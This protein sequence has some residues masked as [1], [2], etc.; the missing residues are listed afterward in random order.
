MSG[1][2]P[3]HGR[4]GQ[5]NTTWNPLQLAHMSSERSMARSPLTWHTPPSH[6]DKVYNLMTGSLMNNLENN[7][8]L[9][10][11]NRVSSSV[12]AP[13]GSV[14]LSL[15][16]ASRSTP[17]PKGGHPSQSLSSTVLP[18]SIPATGGHTVEL[19]AG[20]H[21]T[22]NPARSTAAGN[23]IQSTIA[24]T[25]STT[26]NS[27]SSA[28]A[29]AAVA[30]A[31]AIKERI[32][33]GSFPSPASFN[34]TNN[35][36]NGFGMSTGG[37][38]A[39]RTGNEL[40]TLMTGGL[41]IKDAKQINSEM[42][43]KNGRDCFSHLPAADSADLVKEFIMQTIQNSN[44][45]SV[46]PK[47]NS[48]QRS[49]LHSDYS[50]PNRSRSPPLN[51]GLLGQESFAALMNCSN[52]R[53][54]ADTKAAT[55][56]E[57]S[58]E[59]NNG[60]TAATT[61]SASCAGNIN[62]AASPTNHSITSNE[63]SVDSASGACSKSR[64]RRKPERTNK[65]NAMASVVVAGCGVLEG[66]DGQSFFNNLPDPSSTKLVGAAAKAPTSEANMLVEPLRSSIA[67]RTDITA[68][69]IEGINALS[70][71]LP[72]EPQTSNSCSTSNHS[73]TASMA[74]LA[75]RLNSVQGGV[76]LDGSLHQPHPNHH[77][78]LS[79]QTAVSANLIQSNSNLNNST[80]SSIKTAVSPS[81]SAVAPTSLIGGHNTSIT[82]NTSAPSPS[83]TTNASSLLSDGGLLSV[84][85]A[86]VAA[87]IDSVSKDMKST[88]G[89]DTASEECETL[90]K[91]AAMV[92]SV[93][94]GVTASPEA[95]IGLS[96]PF[97]STN[98]GTITTMAERKCNSNGPVNSHKS[99]S[100]AE[101]KV[102]C[103][104]NGRVNAS[105]SSYEE[106]ENKLEEMFAGIVEEKI[107]D[108]PLKQ[109]IV[110]S[111]SLHS[112]NGSNAGHNQAN[113][114][115]PTDETDGALLK[116]L[117]C[118]N[119]QTVVSGDENNRE[120]KT[121][122]SIANSGTP[123]GGNGAPPAAGSGK[124]PLTPAQK[125]ANGT[126][127]ALGEHPFPTT[128]T[129]VTAAK[130]KRGPKKKAKTSGS[131]F[132]E[133]ADKSGFMGLKALNTK[134]K[135]N[136]KPAAGPTG[137]K[138]K[139]GK[140][141][142]QK[143]ATSKANCPNDRLTMGQEQQGTSMSGWPGGGATVLDALSKHK[144]P[145]VQV[146][147]NGSHSVVNAS[148]NDD[149]GEKP[150]TKL[151]K[152]LAT[153]LNASERSKIRGLHVSTLSTKYDAD[154][155]DIS[156]MCVFCKM[157]PHKFRLGD[158]FGPYIISTAS[159]EYRAGQVDVDY[160]SV[161]RSRDSL[162]STQAKERRMA[163][164]QKQ[165][166]QQTTSGT[167]KGRKRKNAA[168]SGANNA[169]A[170]T[171]PNCTAVLK[172]EKKDDDQ[173]QLSPTDVYYG[174]I[175]ASDSTYEVW[176][177]EDCLVWAPGVY[178]VGTR[179]I[180][181]EAAIWNCCRHRCQLCSQYG[182]VICCLRQGCTA[183][184]HFICAHKQ[185]WKLTDEYQAFC[186]AHAISE[187]GSLDIA[188]QLKKEIGPEQMTDGAGTNSG[189]SGGGN[190]SSAPM[191]VS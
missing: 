105:D 128:S 108:P 16:S 134:G 136:G 120:Q 70:K 26:T 24:S 144:G 110:P 118:E 3:P 43:S 176:T 187:A 113:A 102:K 32:Q 23:V 162:E 153:S 95:G 106:V 57:P 11:Y 186:E 56:V 150:Q 163:E 139:G 61:I 9:Q 81:N 142:K 65:M 73:S 68:L 122:F 12:G 62:P 114:A 143:G 166:K 148:T 137:G 60:P 15:P 188:A 42:E 25:N 124:K 45:L 80:N 149:D 75:N 129:P 86:T 107:G 182:A 169:Q 147:A 36:G 154:T 112:N 145:Y 183:K 191:D 115:E 46:S 22:I 164:Q 39:G 58:V 133:P 99:P 174:M 184:A 66:L 74:E 103:N 14:D 44:S 181:L 93:T 189:V 64:R 156:W 59:A 92:S 109:S 175:K 168:A 91:I 83:I 40:N 21:T 96:M 161:K 104:D 52:M 85:A 33:Q 138:Q 27:S 13:L 6:Q 130:R 101:A 5:P 82:T 98:G 158:L 71:C 180:G 72:S 34:S 97:S 89:T 41:L 47:R 78:L 100:A 18:S 88:G 49:A 87:A 37:G 160:F 131:P 90:D 53:L 17:S 135:K 50:P 55:S 167:G 48:P 31:A 126:K 67:G 19:G 77:H 177:H 51:L 140:G 173:G 7:P 119:N 171:A 141:G 151:A 10:G 30:V 117:S 38:L 127:E 116:Q 146:K 28:S 1:H 121:H 190:S 155:T 35:D 2:N 172:E 159:D 29:A 178:M 123:S 94:A 84:T 79:G 111:I 63:D 8:L 76:H 165:Q 152:K 185:N 179:V 54:G 132:F 69:A 157:G 4:L 20:D 125:R 170:A